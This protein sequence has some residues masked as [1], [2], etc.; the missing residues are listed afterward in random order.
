MDKDWSEACIDSDE[1]DTPIEKSE[2]QME[3]IDISAMEA[4]IGQV[5]QSDEYM[6]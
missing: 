1:E 4:M 2:A 6:I 3:A 5:N